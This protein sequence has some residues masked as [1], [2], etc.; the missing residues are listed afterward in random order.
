MAEK[1][2]RKSLQRS[3]GKETAVTGLSYRWAELQR[4]LAA[5]LPQNAGTVSPE[6]QMVQPCRIQRGGKIRTRG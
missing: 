3:E 1:K 4:V 6:E 2:R 5:V